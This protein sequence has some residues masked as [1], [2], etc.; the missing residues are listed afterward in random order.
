MP[1]VAATLDRELDER[2]SI[3]PG[4]G[5]RERPDPRDRVA[6]PEPGRPRLDAVIA[7]F[8]VLADSAISEWTAA[9]WCVAS[10]DELDG[11]SPVAWARHG[12][13]PDRL[14]QVARR[15]AA[16]LAR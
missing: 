8:W 5:G 2:A 13:D 16:R 9:S 3:R 15:D 14:A 12:T 10:D 6:R 1:I 4:L 7:A 11:L